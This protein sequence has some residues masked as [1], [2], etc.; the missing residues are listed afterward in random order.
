MSKYKLKFKLKQHTPIIHFQY[1][2][3]GAT[4]RASELKPKL[5]KFLIEKLGLTKKIT[6]DSKEKEV[7]K[8]EYKHWF[9]DEGKEHLA[10]NYKVKINTK[11][12]HINNKEIQSRDRIPNFFANM[13][14]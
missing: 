13:G 4:L 5:D 6:I 3:S 7:P 14:K 11:N 1:D 9:I 12:T 10:L 8:S 2:Q